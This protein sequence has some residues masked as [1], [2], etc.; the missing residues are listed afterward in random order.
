MQDAKF[1]IKSECEKPRV[2]WNV[3]QRS[4]LPSSTSQA[5]L[6]QLS[7]CSIWPVEVARMSVPVTGGKG[8]G[9]EEE[10]ALSYHAVAYVDLAPLL[11]PG[12]R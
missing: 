1:R 12:G 7:K 9:K 5:L 8:K 2:S 6:D 10:P 3:Q 4:W 11:Y